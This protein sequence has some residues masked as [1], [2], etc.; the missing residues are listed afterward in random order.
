MVTVSKTEV[1]LP[2]FKSTLGS[3]NWHIPLVL[4]VVGRERI[5]KIGDVNKELPRIFLSFL[6]NRG[7]DAK[8]ASWKTLE[9]VGNTYEGKPAS[10]R[11]IIVQMYSLAIPSCLNLGLVSQQSPHEML[12]FTGRKLHKSLINNDGNLLLE[13]D[14]TF[15]LMRKII[16]SQDK[17]WGIINAIRTSGG[18]G[19]VNSI[20]S[21]LNASGIDVKTN[22]TTL[23]KKVRE[24]V[25]SELSKKGMIRNWFDRE[26]LS[27][28]IDSQVRK[29]VENRMKIGKIS[30]LNNLLSFYSSLGLIKREGRVYALNSNE[31]AYTESTKYWKEATDID[32]RVFFSSLKSNYDSF[33]KRGKTVVPIPL[34]RD[35][36]CEELDMSWDA[37]DQKLT[38]IGYN[39]DGFRISLSRAIYAKRWG[40]NIGRINYYYVS[41]I[42]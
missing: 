28:V 39:F 21:N 13:N 34:V 30:V 10:K 33:R 4:E 9:Y 36:V 18:R 26:R 8:V 41:I 11:Y 6:Q 16:M 32:N 38:E 17:K 29:Q 3:L 5:R 1:V 7:I 42:K 24:D 20:L 40:L 2:N 15:S 25:A 22:V 12:T 19:T 27:G 37:F 14:E 23:T 35:L 31:I